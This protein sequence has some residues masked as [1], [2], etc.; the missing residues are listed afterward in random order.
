M[1]KII[2]IILK[3]MCFCI[4]VFTL[5]VSILLI[6]YLCLVKRIWEIVEAVQ[7]VNLCITLINSNSADHWLYFF[8]DSQILPVG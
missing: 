1:K 2:N 7:N 8:I 6:I 4:L 5:L 3:T